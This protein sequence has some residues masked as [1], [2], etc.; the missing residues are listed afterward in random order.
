MC[1]EGID[2]PELPEDPD[3][4][5]NEMRAGNRERLTGI[6]N[7]IFGKDTRDNWIAKLRAAGVPAGPIRTVGEA[8]TSPEAQSRGIVQKVP[9]SGAGEVPIVRSPMML[10][11][12]P[13]RDPVGSPLHGE[14]SEAVLRDVLGYDAERI[15]ELAA[16]GTVK[17]G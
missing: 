13:V 5:S 1:A 2:A 4:A 6:L 3:F 16:S 10:T 9:H 15:A 17:L 8:M 11:G 7:A 14:H 12:T